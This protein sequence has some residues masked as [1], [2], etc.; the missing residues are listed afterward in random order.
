MKIT[1]SF[2]PSNLADWRDW[3]EQNYDQE[4]EIWLV[5]LKRERGKRLK[6]LIEE[7]M[8]GKPTSMH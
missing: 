5:Y 7:V 2:T 1:K 8:A 4:Q 3:L 6:I